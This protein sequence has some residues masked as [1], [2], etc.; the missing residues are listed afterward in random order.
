MRPTPR[1]L[2]LLLAAV[3]IAMASADSAQRWPGL[4][5]AIGVL[6]GAALVAWPLRSGHALLLVCLPPLGVLLAMLFC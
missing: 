2:A 3:A 4:V 5:V 6:S 1:H